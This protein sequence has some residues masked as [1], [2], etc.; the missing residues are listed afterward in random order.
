MTIDQEQKRILE[1]LYR[2]PYGKT[3]EI[4]LNKAIDEINDVRTMNTLEELL[5]RKIALKF[6]N[7][8]FFFMG[9][10]KVETR[11]KNQYI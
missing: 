4:V 6:I 2:T 7:E 9:E 8:L 11:D 1:E 3:L 10:K 5:G